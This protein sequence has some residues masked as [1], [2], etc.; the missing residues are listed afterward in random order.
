[1]YVSRYLA[2]INV[3]LRS[4]LRSQRNQGVETTR[5][6]KWEATTVPQL[7]GEVAKV[8]WSTPS[9][10]AALTRQD[11]TINSIYAVNQ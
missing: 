3:V 8:A 1:M 5:N 11:K 9:K 2:Y 10:N 6:N 4:D 7:I